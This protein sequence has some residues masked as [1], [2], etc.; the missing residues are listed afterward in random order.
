MHAK[1]KEFCAVLDEIKAMHLKKS[2]DYGTDTDPL[3]NVRSSGEFGVPAWVGVAIRANDKMSRLKSFV[4]KGKLEN[5]SVEDALLD[6]ASYSVIA[7][8]LMRET[9]HELGH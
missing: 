2:A 5:E 9:R 4:A 7:L 1:S 8:V 3:A 6:L